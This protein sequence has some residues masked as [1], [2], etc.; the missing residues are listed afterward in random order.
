MKGAGGRV[1]D[2]PFPSLLSPQYSASTATPASLYSLPGLRL[3]SLSSLLPSLHYCAPAS[4]LSPSPFPPS[5]YP[6][7]PLPPPL[8]SRPCP[9]RRSHPAPNLRPSLPLAPRSALDGS[10]RVSY[11]LDARKTTQL[12]SATRVSSLSSHY[13]R[14]GYLRSALI[15]PQQGFPSPWSSFCLDPGAAFGEV[16]RAN[17]VRASVVSGKRRSPFSP[18]QAPI[19]ISRARVQTPR[20]SFI[21]PSRHRNDGQGQGELSHQGLSLSFGM[22]HDSLLRSKGGGLY[23]GGGGMTPSSEPLRQGDRCFHHGRFPLRLVG[24]L[25]GKVPSGCLM[26]MAAP[27][28]QTKGCTTTPR[29]VH[30]ERPS[31]QGGQTD[32]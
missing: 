26:M 23:L 31:S 5:L 27:P 13:Q 8:S 4:L 32:R 29:G 21:Q 24:L 2:S 12:P 16:P 20:L 14:E 7:T 17:F 10:D 15:V 9:A 6:T 1:L 30:S 3:P 22:D 28:H 19:Q 11:F 25:V 18:L